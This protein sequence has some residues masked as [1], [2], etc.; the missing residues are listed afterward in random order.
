MKRARR[1]CN[2]KEHHDQRNG[3]IVLICFR[4]SKVCENW[5]LEDLCDMDDDDMEAMLGFYRPGSVPSLLELRTGQEPG[6]YEFDGSFGWAV[7]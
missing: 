7:V 2:G 4:M 5:S 3:T 1:E 6:V